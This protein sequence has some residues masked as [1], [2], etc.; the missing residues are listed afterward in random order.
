MY[1]D[2]A[3]RHTNGPVKPLDIQKTK[4]GLL[5]EHQS[6]GQLLCLKAAG[7]GLDEAHLRMDHPEDM[8]L[9]WLSGFDGYG[10]QQPTSTCTDTWP[11]DGFLELLGSHAVLGEAVRSD[12]G[13]STEQ[14]STL[15]PD[16]ASND[17]VHV[18]HA[19]TPAYIGSFVA[20]REPRP[21]TPVER[22]PEEE[23]PSKHKGKYRGVGGIQVD[24]VIS[25]R[26]KNRIAAEKCR[27][28]KR[29]S[30]A[31]L[32]SKHEILEAQHR[33]LLDTVAV[34]VAETHDLKNMVMQHSNCDN[35]LIQRYLDDAASSWITKRRDSGPMEE[36]AFPTRRR[37]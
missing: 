12:L 28:K 29:Y 13:S 8:E 20:D 33:Q 16:P 11:G 32:E 19:S 21:E 3:P 2:H 24:E 27:L 6:H 18:F 7:R 5:V 15:S 14:R 10:Y 35:D 26:E 9:G 25:A 23:R 37:V 22:T 30:V 17:R 34:L 31:Q 4:E 36:S 1:T